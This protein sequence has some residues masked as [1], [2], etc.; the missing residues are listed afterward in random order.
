VH[1]SDG[2]VE[3]SEYKA[4]QG[5]LQ[6]IQFAEQEAAE[7]QRRRES[8]D[9]AKQTFLREREDEASLLATAQSSA[10][11]LEQRVKSLRREVERRV[12]AP[13]V[14]LK[15]APFGSAANIANLPAY[16]EVFI[17]IVTPHWYGVEIPS[18]LRGW[19]PLD[20]LELLP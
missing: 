7:T 12:K 17:V 20:Q 10:Q 1:P 9:L 2:T 6:A 13:G 18:G 19:L 16:T 14:S 15:A 3:S 5:H 8:L 4:I 11:D